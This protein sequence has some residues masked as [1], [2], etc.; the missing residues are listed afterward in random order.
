LGQGFLLE[1]YY[2]RTLPHWQVEGKDLFLTWRLHGSLPATM[3]R[4]LAQSKTLQPGRR[5]REFDLELDKGSSGPN[6]LR[7]ATIAEVMVGGLKEISARGLWKLHA[8]VV[9]S[10]HVHVLFEPRAALGNI[11]RYLKGGTAR[12]AN[13]RLGRT[14][15]HFW[16]DESFDHWVRDDAEFEKVK[17]YIERNPVMAGLVERVEEWEWSSASGK[18]L[19]C[20]EGVGRT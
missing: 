5:F 15:K 2:E 11:M 19:V 9:M 6:W 14:G 8:W 18:H 7:E 12:E 3:M 13:L 4:A 16:Q 10:N 20:G 17:S 1:R